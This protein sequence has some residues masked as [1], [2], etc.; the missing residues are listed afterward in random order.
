MCIHFIYT[1]KAKNTIKKTSYENW[2]IFQKY[3]E[4]ICINFKLKLHAKS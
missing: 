4:F 1:A 3:L 2:F